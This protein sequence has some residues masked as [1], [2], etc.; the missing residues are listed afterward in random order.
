MAIAVP[1]VLIVEDD[2]DLRRMFRTALTLAGFDVLEAGDGY[3]ALNT[4]DQHPP[5]VIVLDLGLPAVS[6]HVVLQELAAKAHT[7]QIP[8]VV[9]TAMPGEHRY[10]SAKCVLRK[11]I[12]P[13]RLVDTV[14]GCLA[15]GSPGG[16]SA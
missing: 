8:V 9:V 6:G 3:G 7:R 14:R 5:D 16:A 1:I 12:A 2:P 11:P 15:A 4:I 10:E 13:D